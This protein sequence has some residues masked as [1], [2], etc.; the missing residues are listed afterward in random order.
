MKKVLLSLSLLVASLAANAQ[1]AIWDA[2]AGTGFTGAGT[3][4][5]FSPGSNSFVVDTATSAPYN[6]TFSGV[7]PSNCGSGTDGC[8]Y[9]NGFGNG[10]YSSGGQSQAFGYTATDFATD[11]LYMN[12]KT[13]GTKVKIQFSTF[14]VTGTQDADMYGYEFD[15]TSNAGTDFGIAEIP[16]SS[17][18]KIV[19]NNPDNTNFLT[20]GIAQYIGKIE[21]VFVKTADGGAGAA[22][23]EVGDIMIG[24]P[25]VAGVNAAAAIAS[26]KL[27]PN[28]VSDMAKV[29]LNLKSASSVKVTLSD[30]MGK[31]VMTIADG[32]FSDLTKEFSVA[33][34]NKGIYTVN[35]Y[36]NGE[37]AKAE[38]LMVK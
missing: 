13:G 22:S 32:T 29:E 9:I 20:A 30:V 7:A 24:T 26:S 37:A 25:P 12:I 31:E 28:P 35:Y 27:Y 5:V 4:F 23:A 16:M 2:T 19:S 18:S 36:I 11:K 1:F 15:F 17:L 14:T 10:S 34:L 3:A 21:I 38:M 6:I 33:T 8:Y